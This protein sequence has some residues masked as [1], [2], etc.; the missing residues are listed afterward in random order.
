MFSLQSLFSKLCCD[1]SCSINSILSKERTVKFRDAVNE[2]LLTRDIYFPQQIIF[3]YS[4]QLFIFFDGSLQD[5]GSCVYAFSNNQFNLLSSSAKI[6]GI[7][8]FSG[9]Q[10]EIAG[11]VLATRMEPKISQKLF[12]VNL[13]P[14]CLLETWRWF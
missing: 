11:A 1:P 13:S 8:A 4:A 9:P 2:I 5:Y 3:N 10:S 12:N 7:A 14:S 6:M